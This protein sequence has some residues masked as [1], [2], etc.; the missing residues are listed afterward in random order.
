MKKKAFW[1]AGLFVLVVAAVISCGYLISGREFS[2]VTPHAPHAGV[3]QFDATPQARNY[4]E[5]KN[6]VIKLVENAQAEGNIRA[7]RLHFGCGGG[8]APGMP[9]G[10]DR[11][12]DWRLCGGHDVCRSHAGTQLLRRESDHLL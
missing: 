10:D 7:L 4:N 1:G 11:D 3:S 9:R 2:T 12:P 8:S 5:L 6:Q